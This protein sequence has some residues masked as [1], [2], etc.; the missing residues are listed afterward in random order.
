MRSLWDHLVFATACV[1]CSSPLPLP[2]PATQFVLVTRRMFKTQVATLLVLCCAARCAEHLNEFLG[3]RWR[4][5]A[6]QNYFDPRG[7]FVSLMFSAPIVLVVLTLV[8]SG[9]VLASLLRP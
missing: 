6:T 7:V 2:L 4:A 1:A 9:A 8:V 3:M 5:F